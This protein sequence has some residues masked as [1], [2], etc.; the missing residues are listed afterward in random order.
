MEGDNK[1]L[2]LS[3]S[4]FNMC[5]Y[6]IRRDDDEVFSNK[7]SYTSWDRLL[8]SDSN[9]NSV[10][11]NEIKRICGIYPVN[12]SETHRQHELE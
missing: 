4:V 9:G 7:S 5:Y 6:I 11:G 1:F 8:V 10:I 2:I 3:S 12:V